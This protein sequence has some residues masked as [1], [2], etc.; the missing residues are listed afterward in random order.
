LLTAV[1]NPSTSGYDFVP[2]V[3]DVGSHGYGISAYV[4]DSDPVSTFD[5]GSTL[6]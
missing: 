6:I 4:D 2:A 1:L 3:R 5:V